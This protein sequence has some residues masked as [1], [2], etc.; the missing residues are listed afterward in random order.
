MPVIGTPVFTPILGPSGTPLITVSPG[1]STIFGK[2]MPAKMRAVAIKQSQQAG[3]L[4]QLLDLIGNPVDLTTYGFPGSGTDPN[5]TIQV[6]FQ[7]ALNISDR[8]TGV[9]GTVIDPTQGLVTFMAPEFIL[10]RSGVR[11]VEAG[12]FFQG[13]MILSN[14][15]YML[16]ER[17]L[18]S[19]QG[20][21]HNAFGPPTTQELRLYLRDTPE[22]NRLTDQYEFDVAEI[23]DAM[24]RSVHEWNTAPPLINIAYDTITFPYRMYWIIGI[25]ANLLENSSH[26]FR[27]TTL[28]YQ[29]GGLAIDDL[30][31]FKEYEAAAAQMR[32]R[33]TTWVQMNK[34]QTNMASGFGTLG[35]P[36]YDG[37]WG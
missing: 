18:F 9:L 15:I 28:P 7:E 34:V 37:W 4:L 16:I 11:L 25:V 36:Y 19:V 35:S 22:G 26:W 21:G 6:A 29:G 13:N 12:A 14:T 23:C 24:V 3:I 32:Q 30:D 1:V 27:R 2:A 8:Q 17:G 5:Y 20:F 10:T 33:W 31:K